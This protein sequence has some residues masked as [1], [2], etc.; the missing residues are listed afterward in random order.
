MRTSQTRDATERSRVSMTKPKAVANLRRIPSRTHGPVAT[1][2]SRVR[3]A[4][5]PLRVAQQ[6]SE[7]THPP[8]SARR[9][10]HAASVAVFFASCRVMA[11]HDRSWR[12]FRPPA[13]TP[14]DAVPP[15]VAA[16]SSS[17]RAGACD[18]TLMSVC[19][20]LQHLW[21]RP[22]PMRWCQCLFAPVGDAAGRCV[23]LRPPSRLVL[24][25]MALCVRRCAC[26]GYWR[27][28]CCVRKPATG[29]PN[30]CV[31][32]PKRV[33]LRT[34]LA[35]STNP[36]TPTHPV[37]TSPAAPQT[38][39][40]PCRSTVPTTSAAPAAATPT[41]PTASSNSHPD[42]PHGRSRPG[43]RTCRRAPW[44]PRVGCAHCF[45]WFATTRRLHS[46]PTSGRFPRCRPSFPLHP[47][48]FSCCPQLPHSE[49]SCRAPF[50]MRGCAWVDAAAAL[51]H[52]SGG[53][54]W[55]PVA[56]AV[57][58]EGEVSVT[59]DSAAP[60]DG[61]GESPLAT[62][63]R[64]QP[65]STSAPTSAPASACSCLSET[66]P[67]LPLRTW[68]RQHWHLRML[69]FCAVVTRTMARPSVCLSL[70]ARRR[71]FGNLAKSQLAAESLR[72]CQHKRRDPGFWASQSAD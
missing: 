8:V 43:V 28:W 33:S 50:V 48:P 15:T 63:S 25:S 6:R 2:A 70:S 52:A 38:G 4:S 35:V 1:A 20:T 37:A 11:A 5:M 49:H 47:H 46:R 64:P 23:V 67:A 42:C 26:I 16:V 21:C 61:T 60:T 3:L 53:G 22:R 69:R 55:S 14:D 36:P 30:A 54:G 45:G 32:W 51:V 12:R 31:A 65:S 44:L 72:V 59:L 71:R 34:M 24:P 39:G 18:D 62:S 57:P 10:N 40:A 13:A 29:V 17:D 9:D 7:W 19:Q 56:S 68:T 41:A 66:T 58:G 27:A